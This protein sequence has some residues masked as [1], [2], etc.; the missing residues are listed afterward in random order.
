M[1]FVLDHDVHVGCRRILTDAGHHCWTVGQAGRATDTDDEQSL[2]A[3]RK[4]AVLISQDREF[5]QRRK[6]AV[7]GR[8]VRLKCPAPD[9]PDVLAA[10]LP[11]LLAILGALEH[12]VVVMSRDTLRTDTTW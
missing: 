1:R 2:Y 7:I 4:G 8:H 10:H 5:T 6:K 11:E 12:V 9:A 3:Q